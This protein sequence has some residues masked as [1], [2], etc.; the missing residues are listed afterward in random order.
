MTKKTKMFISCGLIIILIFIFKTPIFILSTKETVDITVSKTEVKK[1]KGKDLY[2][3]YTKNGETF[4]NEDSFWSWKFNSS[5]IHGIFQED[6]TYSVN[7][8]GV[9]IPI[10]STYRNITSINE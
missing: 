6:S 10:F 3:V 2:L 5:D 8:Y 9:R 7:V 1:T 4:S